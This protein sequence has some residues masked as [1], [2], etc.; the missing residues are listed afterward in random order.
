MTSLP[1]LPQTLDQWHR[2]QPHNNVYPRDSIWQ[3]LVPFFQDQ[4]LVLWVTSADF[5]V[6]PP[7]ENE[8]CPDPF[9]Y[10]VAVS[11]EIGYNP[12]FDLVKTLICPARTLD[13]RDVLIRLV[14]KGD[15]GLNHLEAL[16]RLAVG[17]VGS[18]GDNHTVPV[19]RLI[20]LEDM[21]FAVFPLMAC[22]FIAGWYYQLHEVI[23]ATI[24]LLEGLAFVHGRLVAHRD[25]DNDNILINFVNGP[26]VR[27]ESGPFRSQFPVRYYLNDFEFAVCSAEDSLLSDRLVSGI[28]ILRPIEE[29]GRLP[30]PE[31]L[32][33][34]PY[35]PF[36]CDIWQMGTLFCETFNQISALPSEIKQLYLEMTDGNPL[37]RPTAAVALD[38]LRMA[39][40]RT[41]LDI[42]RSLSPESIPF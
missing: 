34:K 40:D 27:G 26:R 35:C 16:R 3:H 24:Q 1:Y 10:R 14:A 15:N 4:G 29:Y 36:K 7:N 17:N 22:G 41:P 12:F 31:M 38:R 9:A 6:R 13:D 23:D 8:R 28:P 19:L 25:I 2:Y 30:A 32:S 5:T 20:T 21:T 37:N 11:D 33:G 39:R 18:R 42:L